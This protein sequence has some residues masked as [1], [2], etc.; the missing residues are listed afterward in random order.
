M[1]IVTTLLL[2]AMMWKAL[3]AATEVL[4]MLLLIKILHIFLCLKDRSNDFSEQHS[5]R[6][7]ELICTESTKCLT[8]KNSTEGKVV[9][10][11]HIISF[12]FQVA[13]YMLDA[14]CHLQSLQMEHN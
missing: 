2:L 9:Y 11:K 7:E 14:L 8:I 4:E 13:A 3:F 6:I 12:L 10:R 1:S 5:H